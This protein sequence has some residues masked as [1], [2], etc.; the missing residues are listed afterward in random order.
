MNI[1]PTVFGKRK[2]PHTVI[3]ARGDRIRH[4]TIRPWVAALAGTA[5]AV[6]A[7]GYLVATAYLV[8]RDDLMGAAMAR[9]ARMQQAYEDRISTLRA[10]VDRITSRQLLDQQLMERKVSKLIER[11]EQLT[12]RHGRLEPILERSRPDKHTAVPLPSPRPQ[13]DASLQLRGTTVDTTILTA[14]AYAP[15]P[16]AA[17]SAMRWPIRDR[18]QPSEADQA[19]RLFVAINRSLRDIESEQIARV[20]VLAEEAYQTAEEIAQALAEAGVRPA[21]NFGTEAVGGPLLA[22]GQI[23]PFDEKVRE[24][25]EA[26]NTLEQLKKTARQVPIANPL[27]GARV[28]SMFGTRR[29]PLLGRRAH[30]SG[31]DF[32][33][34]T[35][36]PIKAAGAGKVI[37]AG[38]NGGYGRMVEID[39]G[40]GLTTRYAHMS[41]I[42]VGVGDK[43]SPGS[44]IGKV[45]SSGRSTGPHLHYEVRKS[46]KPIN[47]LRFIKAGRNIQ[48]LL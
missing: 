27:P 46:G 39:H 37:R 26:L 19:D 29:D 41:R 8:V 18:A 31:M 5:M 30:H 9:Q 21:D 1:Q 43:V 35:G 15:A 45:G 2:E 22:A 7:G 33:G 17:V 6:I 16:A 13:K 10:Q 42:D 34:K 44:V 11:Q 23:G 14:S 48:R 3:I 47:P 4:F 40:N 32:S 12:K 28:T 36:T 20:E 25:D 38:W 24:L